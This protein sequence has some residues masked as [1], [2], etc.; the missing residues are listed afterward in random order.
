MVLGAH[1]LLCMTARFFGK[2]YFFPK[3]E[4]NGPKM[5]EKIEFLKFIGKFSH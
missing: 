5:G 2:K 3:N 1:A 4:E